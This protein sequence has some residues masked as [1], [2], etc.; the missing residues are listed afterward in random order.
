MHYSTTYVFLY[1]APTCFSIAKRF[2]TTF[3]DD[4]DNAETCRS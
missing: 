1:L 3:P 4:D 2:N